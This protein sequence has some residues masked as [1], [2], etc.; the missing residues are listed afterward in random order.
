[1]AGTN[2]PRRWRQTDSGGREAG[3]GVGGGGAGSEK[4]RDRDRDKQRQRETER[5]GGERQYPELRCQHQDG[6]A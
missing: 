5:A 3:G 4:D 2:S 1:M 6:S